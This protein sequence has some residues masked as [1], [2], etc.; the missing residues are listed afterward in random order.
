MLDPLSCSSSLTIDISTSLVV[1]F[2][3]DDSTFSSLSRDCDFSISDTYEYRADPTKTTIIPLPFN[4]EI[5]VA[6]TIVEMAIINTCFTFPAIHKV[7]GEVSLLA[8]SEDILS[9]K[10]KKPLITT[11]SMG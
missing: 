5:G 1:E 9:A 6:K 10:E 7:R 4:G 3:D 2:D 11:T 8:I